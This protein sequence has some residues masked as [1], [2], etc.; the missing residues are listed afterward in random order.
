MKMETKEKAAIIIG[1]I[2]AAGAIAYALTRKGTPPPGTASLQGQVT[3]MENVPLIGVTVTLDSLQ[4]STDINGYYLL[5][6]IAPGNY[7]VQFEKEGYQ[8]ETY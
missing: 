4:T 8:T 1:G 3:D 2:A 6:G 5:S 7:T